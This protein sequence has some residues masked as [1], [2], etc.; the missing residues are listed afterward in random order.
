M[1]NGTYR[2]IELV[3]LCLR[4]TSEVA[5]PSMFVIKISGYTATVMDGWVMCYQARL[6]SPFTKYHL[7]KILGI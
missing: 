2:H 1:V 4:G 3:Y 7:K 6:V 5:V